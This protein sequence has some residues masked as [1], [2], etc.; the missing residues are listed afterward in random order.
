MKKVGNVLFLI[1]MCVLCVFSGLVAIGGFF[2]FLAGVDDILMLTLFWAAVSVSCA[3]SI[4]KRKTANREKSEDYKSDQRKKADETFP[5]GFFKYI[6]CSFRSSQYKQTIQIQA[7]EINRLNGMLTD[8]HG[9]SI[10]IK[11]HL[12][13]LMRQQSEIEAEIE[14]KKTAVEEHEAQVERLKSE[15]VELEEVVLLQD[16]G[17]YK[18]TY[19]FSTS[20]EYK[21]RLEEIRS[22]QK[23]MVKDKIAA[24]CSTEWAVDNDKRK[25]RKMINDNIKQTLL[26][27]NTECENA[28]DR[29]KFSNYDSM[30]ARIDKIYEKLNKLN[31]SLHIFISRR[32]YELKI[33]ELQLAFE[34]AR[35]KQEEKEY[36][37]EQ[38]EIQRENARV[39][40]ELEAERRRIEKEQTHYE[41][42]MARLTEQLEG[43]QN[44]ARKEIILDK[45]EAV[46][47]ELID[48]DKALE[49][50]DYRQAN[51]RAGYVYI[52]SNIGSF[53]EGI[54]KIG[55][56]RRLE[57]M[58]RVDEL[59][60]ASVPFRFDVHALIFSADAPK[61]ETAL[62]KAFEDRRVNMVNGRKEFYRVSLDEIEAVVRQNHD[63]TVEFKHIPVAE[64]YRESKKV[65][66]M[67][68]K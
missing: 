66:E 32:Y 61:L 3:F 43:E 11:K 37:R 39:Q 34:Y 2:S 5:K 13:E 33:Q 6:P 25:G 67:G 29:V 36:A 53:G 65:W 28:I 18:P 10:E 56:T 52:I 42:Q 17:L 24:T 45:I 57:P 54:Y 60:D 16:F 51:E 23:Q 44:E 12:E 7:E 30:K 14:K 9:Q 15:I 63:K 20:E 68:A 27:F 59:G 4:K 64:Q 58:D 22:E 47:S 38:R 50:V 46:K 26:T 55:M 35:K 21:S 8:E 40:K 41:N 1:F 31:D 62:H 49:D 19:D 48:L